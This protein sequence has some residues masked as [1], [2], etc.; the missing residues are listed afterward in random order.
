MKEETA[1]RILRKIIERDYPPRERAPYTGGR[2][3]VEA[4][5]KTHPLAVRIEQSLFEELK[6]RGLNTGVE[7]ERA[8][9]IYLRTLEVEG[10]R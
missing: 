7:V 3:R 9:R 8:L 10:K 4:D 2:A 5:I 6:A 1:L